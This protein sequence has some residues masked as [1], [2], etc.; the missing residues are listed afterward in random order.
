MKTTKHRNGDATAPRSDGENTAQSQSSNQSKRCRNNYDKIAIPRQDL[1][2]MMLLGSGEFGEV[3]LAQANGLQGNSETVVM[4]KALQHMRDENLLQEFKR[5]LD[6]F[7]R[8]DHC[9]IAKLLGICNDMEPHYM[10][11]QYTDWGDLKQFLVATRKEGTP[12]K[13]RPTPLTVSQNMSIIHQIALAMEHLANHRMVHKDLAARNCL[14]SSDLS[15]KV[16]LSALCKDTYSKEYSL[17]KNQ[18]IPLRWLPLE[19]VE[20]DDYSC[21][22]D[23]YS[24]AVT[25]W[26]IF[27][28]GEM[29][30][31]RMTDQ[32]VL[33]LLERGDLHWKH[34]KTTPESLKQLL[35]KCWET[36]P[37]DRPT[38]SQIAVQVGD[39][40]LVNNV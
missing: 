10:I 5:Q 29:P 12:S 13:P 39:S 37:R 14:I 9:N 1:H 25:V 40:N 28:R 33:S 19:A 31:S 3:Y 24:F 18:I 26:E 32:E 21:K 6:M 20:E 23:V 4:V 35:S 34:H 27:S 17:H 16:S 15:V 2:N 36:S 7:G 22:S 8:L 38:F 30:F 11:L